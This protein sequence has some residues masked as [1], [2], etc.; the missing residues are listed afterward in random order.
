MPPELVEEPA[1]APELVEGPRRGRR[2]VTGV[3]VDRPDGPQ[4]VRARRV[5]VAAGAYHSPALLRRGGQYLLDHACVALN[6]YGKD[7]LLA[8]L[9]EKEW[10]PTNRRRA[11]RGS[12]RC[13]DGPYDIHVFIVAGECLSVRVRAG[14]ICNH[15]RPSQ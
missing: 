6:L 11:G 15:V 12:S 9:A 2:L 1:N 13:D 3:E 10:N 4:V 5:V 7:G 14:G 8:E